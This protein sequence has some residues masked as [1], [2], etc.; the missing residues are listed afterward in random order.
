VTP[1]DTSINVF[2]SYQIVFTIA[3]QLIAGSFIRIIFP[4]ALSVD[5]TSAC[6]D[7]ITNTSS[8]CNIT[9]NNITI[10]ANGTILPSTS[11]LVTVSKVKNAADSVKS[12]SFKF[13]TYYD[14]LLDSLVDYLDT[15]VTVNMTANPIINVSITPLN[16]TVYNVGSYTFSFT[17]TD[18]IPQNGY[19]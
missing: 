13:Y 8:T 6:N 17:L 7:N 4:S 15:G 12:G 11:F 5:Q 3:N 16:L 10:T 19:I 14:S 9:S 2:T 1:N 18:D